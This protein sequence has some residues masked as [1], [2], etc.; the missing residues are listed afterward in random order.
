M[1]SGTKMYTIGDKAYCPTYKED[2]AFD[3]IEEVWV[4]AVHF[5]PARDPDTWYLVHSKGA[6]SLKPSTEV[7]D[8]EVDA[9]RAAYIKVRKLAA[10]I[11]DSVRGLKTEIN[12]EDEK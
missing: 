12:K 1:K 5:M 7:F 6:D 2:G 11:Y 3:R 4:R 9:K 8:T 10:A